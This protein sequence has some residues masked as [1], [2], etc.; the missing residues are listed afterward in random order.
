MHI[1]VIDSA[2]ALSLSIFVY[3]FRRIPCTI[4]SGTPN[5]RSD[6][7]TRPAT[8]VRCADQYVC[9]PLSHAKCVQGMQKV[10]IN[11][12]LFPL[13]KFQ[14]L[15]TRHDRWDPDSCLRKRK[16]RKSVVS[17]KKIRG[18]DGYAEGG[19]NLRGEK[20]AEEN[21]VTHNPRSRMH[22]P[23]PAGPRGSTATSR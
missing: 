14:K 15:T 2:L 7:Q 23:P 3:T 17:L 16:K 9:H 4:L 8:S 22:D 13:P 12:F 11:V 1:L 5:P 21:G 6:A 10:H 20:R 19:D 18:A